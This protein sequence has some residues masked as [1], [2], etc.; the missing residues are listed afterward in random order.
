M[1]ADNMV[2]R[3]IKDYEIRGLVTSG[4]INTIY[5]AYQPLLKRSVAFRVL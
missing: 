3:V 1:N 5:D 4:R 2:G